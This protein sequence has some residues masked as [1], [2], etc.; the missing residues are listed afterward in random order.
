MVPGKRLGERIAELGERGTNRP[1]A[2][3]GSL[4]L[5]VAGD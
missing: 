4:E 2:V 5:S 3:A 1:V